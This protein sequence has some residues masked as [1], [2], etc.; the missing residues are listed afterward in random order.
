MPASAV[1]ILKG[2]S[3]DP[4][5][6]QLG[7]QLFGK[8]LN[9]RPGRQAS[10]VPALLQLATGAEQQVSLGDATGRSGVGVGRMGS[11]RMGSI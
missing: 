10:Y 4:D 7:L 6:Y 5:T 1:D 2:F 3:A 9:G 11:N 8:L